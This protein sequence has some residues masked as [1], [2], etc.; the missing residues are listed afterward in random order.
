MTQDHS[1][2]VNEVEKLTESVGG[3]NAIKVT[4]DEEAQRVGRRAA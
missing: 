3:S 1:D 4:E 2:L